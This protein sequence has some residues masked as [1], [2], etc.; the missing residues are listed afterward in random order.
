MHFQNRL[1]HKNYKI[2]LQSA[3]FHILHE[4][5]FFPKNVAALER[6]KIH[7]SFSKYSLEEL[8]ATDG[9]FVASK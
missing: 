9:W 5:S 3:G 7:S 2:M 4:E 8:K 6:I 1:R